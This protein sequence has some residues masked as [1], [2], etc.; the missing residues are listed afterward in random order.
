MKN[1]DPRQIEL[2]EE[3]R[4]EG[5]DRAEAHANPRFKAEAFFLIATIPLGAEFTTDYIWR[6][7]PPDCRTREPRAMGAIIRSAFKQGLIEQVPRT[8]KSIR[9]IAHRNP[10]QVWRRITSR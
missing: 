9:P 6:L 1:N 7:L 2:G 3:L 4:D 5:I 8:I 10:K